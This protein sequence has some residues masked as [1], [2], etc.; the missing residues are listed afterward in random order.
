[1][2]RK[3]IDRFLEY[4]DNVTETSTGWTAR[5][6]AHSDHVNSLSVAEG[7]DGRVLFFCHAGCHF[8]DV[9][10]ALGLSARDLFVRAKGA[11]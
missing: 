7:N 3:P 11:K 2:P 6:P 9:L 10:V 1:M 4:L 8:D 5:C